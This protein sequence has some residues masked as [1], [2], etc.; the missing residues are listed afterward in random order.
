MSEWFKFCKEKVTKIEK[1]WK[2]KLEDNDDKDSDEQDEDDLEDPAKD[3]EKDQYEAQ[4][5]EMFANF[6]KIN[7]SKSFSGSVDQ[8]AELV[9]ARAEASRLGAK[10]DMEIKPHCMDN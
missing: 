10:D 2:R 5:Q 1:V 4:L 6:G 3:A 7:L 9:K 8:P